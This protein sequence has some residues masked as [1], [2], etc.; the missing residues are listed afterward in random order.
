MN[1]QTSKAQTLTDIMLMVFR[2]NGRLLDKGDDLVK[3]LGINSARWQLLGAVALAGKALSAPQIGEAMGVTRQGAQKQLNKMVADGFFVP[4]PNPHHERSPL[5]SLT[6][7][8][9]CT[10]EKT[11]GRQKVWATQLAE[12]LADDDLKRA[13]NLLNRLHQ[14]LESPVPPQG[15]TQ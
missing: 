9:R 8:G 15:A 7:K 1:E 10:V 4:E 11:M 6:E 3:T 12:G 2:L 5:Y 13:L 14:R